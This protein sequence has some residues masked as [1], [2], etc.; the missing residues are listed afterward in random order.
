MNFKYQIISVLALLLFG[1]NLQAQFAW[2]DPPEP[3]VREEVTIYVDVAQD[4]DCQKLASSEGP[5]YLWTWNPSD[6]NIP[7]GNGAWNNSNEALLM[8]HEGGTVWSFTYIPAE[9]YNVDNFKEIYDTGLSFLVKEKDGGAGG[10]CSAEGD[11][12]KTSDINL[13]VP[14][15]FVEPVFS[16]PSLVGDTAV[17][18]RPD[19]IFTLVYDNRLE[20]K[21]TM[22][23]ADELWVYARAFDADDNQY[24][25]TSLGQLGT[26]PSL[27]M[28]TDGSGIFT[29][30]VIPDELFA[31]VIPDGVD[32]RTLQFQIVKLPLCGSDCAVDGEFL[33][34]FACD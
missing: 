10:D 33:Y 17:F 7:D 26:N 29:F 5:M 20:E 30:S 19:D 1:M 18:S 14:S 34:N 16:I 12:F 6:P 15:P 32:I 9:F 22:Q 8:T 23:N 31:A 11:E 25:A 13:S 24:I 4:P 28:V 21:I 3:D 2:I 27:Q